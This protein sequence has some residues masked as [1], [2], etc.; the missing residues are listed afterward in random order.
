M[1]RF[2][3]WMLILVHLTDEI[4]NLWNDFLEIVGYLQTTP[5]ITKLIESL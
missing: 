2:F 1:F 5:H 4:L 3:L